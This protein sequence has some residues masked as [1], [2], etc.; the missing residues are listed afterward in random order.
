MVSNE[1]PAAD[2]AA[3][4][5]YAESVKSGR[6]LCES[7][8]PSVLG[9]VLNSFLCNKIEADR[10]YPPP[11]AASFPIRTQKYRAAFNSRLAV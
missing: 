1:K 5:G 7:R 10:T 2:R 8:C 9:S 6:E 11:I 4:V 3:G